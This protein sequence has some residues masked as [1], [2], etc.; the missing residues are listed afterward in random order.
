M[1]GSYTGVVDRI[2]DGETAVILV[3]SEDGSRVIDQIDAP[4][5]RLPREGRH[6]GA[7][8]RVTVAD[9]EFVEADYRED[10]TGTR[11]EALQERFDR[12]SDRLSDRRDE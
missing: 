2:V 9:G 8:L 4:A 12:H 5:D 10:E 7:V 1:D 6:E 11:Q 3:E